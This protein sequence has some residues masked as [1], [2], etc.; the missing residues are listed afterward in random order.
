MHA[1]DLH[2]QYRQAL[3]ACPLLTA[4]QE[5]V[6]AQRIE[7]GDA[8][9]VTQFTTA[10]LRLVVSIARRYTGRGLPL[11]DLVQEGNLGLLRAVQKFDWRL[12]HRFSTYA[13]WSIRQT[14]T[15]A[16]AD[17]SRPIRLPAHVQAEVRLL[18][19]AEQTLI[20]QG[21]SAPTDAA[22]AQVLGWAPNQVAALRRV[23]MKVASLDRLVG[24][25]EETSVAD[26][27]ADE[28]TPAPEEQ[29]YRTQLREV[30]AQ[31]LALLTPNERAVVCHRFGLCRDEGTGEGTGEGVT[32]EQVGQV[33][34]ITRERVRQIEHTAL[35]K[36]RHQRVRSQLRPYLHA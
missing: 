35:L 22:L 3:A 8:Q 31:V 9:A 33:L 23:Q 16:L 29:I 25:D 15:E 32:L 6:L 34:G 12:G 5:Q 28:S 10:N 21:G 2:P 13:T 30:T 19:Q 14:I 7:Q 1:V 18:H 11:D 26:L 36:L 4:Q 24:E 27:V 17:Q 20:Q